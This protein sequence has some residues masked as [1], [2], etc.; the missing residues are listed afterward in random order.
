MHLHVLSFVSFV[1]SVW[2]ALLVPSVPVHS[3]SLSLTPR[4]IR[5]DGP[6][7]PDQPP[8]CPICE[9]NYGNIN[10]CAAA[11]PVFANFSMIL[12]NPGA[13]I[14]VIQC[15]CTDTFQSAYPQCVDCF[16]QTNQTSFLNVSSANDVPSILTGIRNICA[17]ESTLLGNVSG[18][19]GEVTSSGAA[20]TPTA[21]ASS[22][23]S[24]S[25]ALD[26][27]RGIY[28]VMLGVTLVCAHAA[29]FFI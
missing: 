19:D 10:S 23:S 27:T 20:A 9:Q 3:L 7:F 24:Q 29:S 5:D 17:L 16:E 11:C 28:G 6:V 15:A 12:F 2:L 4:Q 25:F 8:S 22:S 14:T 1:C 26:G 13:F 21:V 18:A